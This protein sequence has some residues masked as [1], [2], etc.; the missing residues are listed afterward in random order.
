MKIY[1]L[2][3]KAS[4]SLIALMICCIMLY[5]AN[6]IFNITGFIDEK[7]ESIKEK[8][9]KYMFG[10]IGTL[11]DDYSYEN[12]AGYSVNN[13]VYQ[14]DAVKVSEE[15]TSS[16]GEKDRKDYLLLENK[17]KDIPVS[18]ND[19]IEECRKYQS[20]SDEL[21]NQVQADSYRNKK[22]GIYYIFN[23]EY[24]M[25]ALKELDTVI[26]KT[27]KAQKMPK[28]LVTSVL[29]REMMFLGQEDL[30][31]GINFIGGK[32]MGLCQIG[33]ENVRFNENTVHGKAS[34]IAGKTDDEI[35][36]MLQ[37]P[38]QAVYFCAV[39]LRARAITLTGNKDID[40]SKLDEKQL[41]K[42]LEEYNQSNIAK[43]IG[44]VKTKEKYAEETYKY[45]Q[46]ISRL[47]ECKA[48]R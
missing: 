7:A 13:I 4:F 40:L 31:D 41:H 39:Q 25:D 16:D 19:Y 43:T 3:R 26:E 29:F 35:R 21:K 17:K 45:Y 37:N 28:A 15:S 48:G 32:S 9:M 6:S 8:E 34:I 5:I 30:L 10:E 23:Y 1:R 36:K 47:Y 27:A 20:I 24:T 42:I 14:Q 38:N 12:T 46:I 11:S 22:F 2:K 18:I 33:I 44:P